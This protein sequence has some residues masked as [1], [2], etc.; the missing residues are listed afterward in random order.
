MKKIWQSPD[1]A[2]VMKSRRGFGLS[3]KELNPEFSRKKKLEGKDA[4]GFV[5]KR[6]SGLRE[7]IKR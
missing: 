2:V 3:K 4:L 5:R 6:R 1:Q 7:E